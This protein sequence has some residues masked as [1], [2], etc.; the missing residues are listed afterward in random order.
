MARTSKAISQHGG[1]FPT[2]R[3]SLL[4]AA[5]GSSSEAD[6]ALELLCR[7]YWLPVYVYIR[8]FGRSPH[9]A[10]D[11]SQEFFTALSQWDY[12]RFAPEEGTFRSYVLKVLKRFLVEDWRKQKAWKRGGRH[13]IVPID[14]E[15]GEGWL[16]ALGD[17]QLSPDEAFDKQWASSLLDRAYL[18]LERVYRKM[19]KQEDFA[20]LVPMLSGNQDRGG[21]A[22]LGEQLGIGEAGARMAVFRMRKRYGQIVRDE[23]AQIVQDPDDVEK[24]LEHFF[25]ALRS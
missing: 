1:R 10:E 16:D 11:L 8:R 22:E 18:E 12:N 24:E 23:I 21:F 14:R 2:T 9:D 17:D 19:G 25:A 15:A 5:A 3:W 6:P 4:A 13:M 20:K 7:A